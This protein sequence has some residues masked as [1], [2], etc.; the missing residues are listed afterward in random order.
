MQQTMSPP[1]SK[2]SEHD[3]EGSQSRSLQFP[4]QQCWISRQ[5]DRCSH[6][7]SV[8]RLSFVTLPDG[9]L[10]HRAVTATGS[11]AAIR[12]C[13]D[14]GVALDETGDAVQRGAILQHAAPAERGVLA[15]DRTGRA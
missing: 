6:W 5:A 1:Q 11:A 13:T 3:V 10:R 12:V 4:S 8:R 9:E 2:S 7:N 15:I 14:V